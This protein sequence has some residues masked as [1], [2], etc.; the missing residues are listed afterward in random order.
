MD[1]VLDAFRRLDIVAGVC[2]SARMGRADGPMVRKRGVDG[3]SC[4]V[5][6]GFACPS[7]L[8]RMDGIGIGIGMGMDV[9]GCDKDGIQPV[10]RV[11]ES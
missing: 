7:L 11:V 6:V 9:G 8:S 3:T 1:Y 5:V 4:I 10:G 2:Q